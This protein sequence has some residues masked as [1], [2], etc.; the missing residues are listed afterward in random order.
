MADS[1]L[2]YAK[3]T[4]RFGITVGDDVDADE[5]PEI[6]YCTSGSIELY[7]LQSPVK[8]VGADPVPLTL[9]NAVIVADINAEGYLEYR[10][11]PRVWVVDLT[12]E[13][14]NPR[15]GDN[16]ATHEVRFVDMVA[17]DIPVTFPGGPVRITAAGPNG[18]GINDLTTLLPVQPG[19]AE[20]IF[21]GPRG[22]SIESASVEGGDLVL[23]LD[24][25]DELNAGPLPVGPGGSDLG[26]ASYVA[27]PTSET[28]KELSATF[29]PQSVRVAPT[30]GDAVVKRLQDVPATMTVVLTGHSLIYGQDT[31][32]T[33]TVA[34]GNGSDK[35]RNPQRPAVSMKQAL[36]NL[37]PGVTI[38]DQGFPGDRADQGI[39]RWAGGA[40]G[41]VEFIWYEQNEALQ[42]TSIATYKTSIQALVDRAISRG[43]QPI[44]L[45]GGPTRFPGA[46]NRLIRAYTAVTRQV[47]ARNGIPYYDVGEM[48]TAVPGGASATWAG[49]DLIHY[50]TAA[51]AIIGLKLAT[52][53]GPWGI[54]MP[55]AAPGVVLYP[56]NGIAYAGTLAS[57]VTEESA[58]LV[59]RMG[60]GEVTQIPVDVSVPC[61]PIVDYRASSDGNGVGTGAI[62]IYFGNAGELS[63]IVNIP[64]HTDGKPHAVR[65]QE[66]RGTGPETIILS[67]SSGSLEVERIRFVAPDT[68]YGYGA[69]DLTSTGRRSHRSRLSGT[70][71]GP[72]RAGTTYDALADP[73]CPFGGGQTS[74]ADTDEVDW[75]VR[76]PQTGAY[77]CLAASMNRNVETLLAAGYAFRR[78]NAD[79][80]VYEWTT[81][82][83]V[84]LLTTVTGVFPA[85]GAWEGNVQMK[86][87]LNRNIEVL[88]DGVSAYTIAV[89]KWV[90]YIPAVYNNGAAMTNR[91]VTV[92]RR[93]RG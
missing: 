22:T 78:H 50:S 81:G 93:V 11:V 83:A 9:G 87:A 36:D 17:G 38:V 49:T 90:H 7:P 61:V 79:L 10:G 13:K 37:L 18:D 32:A 91:A 28:A 24:N 77:L 29:V 88:I 86:V 53:L 19:A 89:G 80:M 46:T 76:L 8:V 15:I 55:K 31:S 52:I 59:I 45:G 60:P 73:T 43:S 25:G 54:P 20:P 4:G 70:V 66:L 82:A 64:T 27:D 56:A 23:A 63:K 6:I 39:T 72:A 62:N 34:P 67:C 69:T 5:L 65:G 71:V 44:L 68:L 47:A 48:L 51:Y 33:G 41:D 58:D 40:S 30:T 74:S 16:A 84:S 26:V 14:V 75:S 35:T 12:S 57:R 85:T 3:V 21:Q 1:D 92:R 42:K 2:D